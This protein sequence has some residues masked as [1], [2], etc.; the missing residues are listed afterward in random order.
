MDTDEV[1]LI[2][3]GEVSCGTLT[4]LQ[5]G[6]KTFAGQQYIF[7]FVY[8]SLFLSSFRLSLHSFGFHQMKK[9]TSIYVTQEARLDSC[10]SCKQYMAINDKGARGKKSHQVFG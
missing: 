9:F 7:L 1:H 4:T 6:V 10:V 2:G 5:I 3:L 8:S